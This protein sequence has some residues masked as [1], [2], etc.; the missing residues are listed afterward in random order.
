MTVEM[1]VAAERWPIDGAF[2]ISRGSK[3]AAE[4][5]VVT[6][7]RGQAV[8]R[9]ECVPY[10]RYGETV[11]GVRAA[12]EALAPRLGEG[13]TR[14]ALDHLLPAGAARNALDCALWDLA[15]KETA[16][17]VW[18]LTGATAAPEAVATAVTV[19]IDTPAAMAAK[20]ATY[21]DWPLLKVKVGDDQVLE[22]VAAV[23]SAAAAP[24]LIVD[25]N[26]GW[27]LDRLRALLPD[28]A[29]MRV[30]LIEQPLPADQD[31]G[32][33]GVSPLVPLCADESAHTADGVAALADRYQAVNI[34]LDKTGGLTEALRMRTAAR[35]AGLTVMVGC[36]VATSLAMAPALLLAGDADFV[37]LDGP[38]ML[39][40]DRPGGL[41]YRGAMVAPSD[42]CLWG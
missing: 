10:A 22:R 19:G 29:A 30:D 18:R 3:T 1:T 40:D 12:L 17:P 28:L 9:G 15:A 7:R 31:D 2:T 5:V 4:V 25:A 8:G 6:L 36:M 14:E 24:A 20:A 41:R 42:P 11:E 13:L 16:T 27:S 37:D 38:L 21:A 23:R 35:A 33:A 32:L 34:K 26:E 39:K